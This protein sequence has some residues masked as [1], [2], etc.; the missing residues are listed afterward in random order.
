MVGA[1]VRLTGAGTGCG[2]E[3][4]FCNGQ[5]VPSS[6]GDSTVFDFSHRLLSLLVSLL[7]VALV[8]EAWGWRKTK[9]LLFWGSVFTLVLL[10]AQIILGA[11]TAITTLTPGIEVAHLG[12]AQLFLAALAVVTLVALA[13]WIES[14]SGRPISNRWTGLGWTAMVAAGSAFALILTGG[15]LATSKT[16]SACTQWPL[17]NGRI[18]PTGFAPADIHIIH[19]W[20]AM[21]TTIAL[22][23]VVLQAR[24]LRSDSQALLALSVSVAT[25]T[26]AQIFVGAASIWFHLNPILDVAH[27]GVATIVWGLLLTIAVL[28]RML[29]VTEVRASCFVESLRVRVRQS[30]SD[31]LTLTKPNVMILL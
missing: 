25:I 12:L 15:Y 13:P 10:V 21:I 14:V 27:L 17:C 5:F 11:I 19:R 24:R 23:G 30:F 2:S 31:Y 9:P 4:P 28:D 22:I 1:I 29:P 20:I 3:W 8:V 18:F 16:A 26:F 6:T 7:V